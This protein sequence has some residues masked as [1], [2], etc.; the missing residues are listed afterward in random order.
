M[1]TSFLVGLLRQ[2]FRK[3]VFGAV[4]LRYD[5]VPAL[6]KNATRDFQVTPTS[7]PILSSMNSQDRHA[8]VEKKVI[9][10]VMTSLG[11]TT[12]PAMDQ[13]LQELGID[14]IGAVE[15]R[16]SLSSTLGIKLPATAMF[17]YPTVGAMIGYVNKTIAEQF[18]G[19]NLGGLS[20]GFGK[21]S[22]TERRVGAIAI[23]GAA[24]H[25]PGGSTTTAR[26]WE[27]LQAGTD[28]M[29]EIPLDR[30]NMF[31]FYNRDP[32]HPDTTYAKLG[33]MVGQPFHF[34]NSLFNISNIEAQVMDPQQR[35]MMEVA[36][37]AVWSAGF[38]KT[39]LVDQE[40]GCFVGCCN[41]DWHMLELPSGS[42][43]GAPCKVPASAEGHS[44]NR[45]SLRCVVGTRLLIFNRLTCLKPKCSVC[46]WLVQVLVEPPQ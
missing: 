7:L 18:S 26:F 35:L 23:V 15:L 42:F 19:H 27:M 41:S 32:D 11:L 38:E 40:I 8:F 17:D 10:L 16:N 9:E 20:S 2:L 5:R 28:C 25:M 1:C 33:A 12:P 6:L 14:S 24:C 29:D 3:W 37:D 22:K 30:W 36:Y 44:I 21:V 39:D 45:I 46:C 13:P 31:A 4:S 34:D 43:T